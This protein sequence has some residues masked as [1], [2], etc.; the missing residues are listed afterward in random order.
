MQKKYFCLN[1]KKA[2][3]IYRKIS[4]IKNNLKVQI[5]IIDI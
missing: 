4:M 5:Y 3:N 2:R 1:I